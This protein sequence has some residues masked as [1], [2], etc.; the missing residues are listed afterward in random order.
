M[1]MTPELRP[2]FKNTIISRYQ[3]TDQIAA[4]IKMAI[5]E[6]EA[7]ANYLSKHFKAG[8]KI[9]SLR[10]IYFFTKKTI[11]YKKE[12]G[13]NQTSKTLQRILTDSKITG[14]DC[15]H[16]S[17]TIA[18]LC[19]SLN[20]PVKLRLVGQSF[21]NNNLT[22]IYPVAIIGNKEY[23]MDCCVSGFNQECRRTVKKDIKI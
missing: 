3:N 1:E 15:K 21:L 8:N 5:N 18:A 7:A 19:K 9:D 4:A 12:P 22:H 2:N 11:P 6:S 17:I 10:L 16:Y 14:G 23:I 20:I 13:S